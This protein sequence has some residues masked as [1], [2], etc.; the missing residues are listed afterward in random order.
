MDYKEFFEEVNKQLGL[1]SKSS[2][3]YGPPG[4]TTEELFSPSDTLLS[5]A[6]SAEENEHFEKV[7]IVEFGGE[8]FR[9]VYMSNHGSIKHDGAEINHIYAVFKDRKF[10]FYFRVY[11]TYSSYDDPVW[12]D[13]SEWA[14]VN[15]QKVENYVWSIR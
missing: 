1:T 10:L 9:V 5:L 14:V 2:Y 13:P 7:G 6:E 8:E 4:L 15:P 3:I 11:G 12:E